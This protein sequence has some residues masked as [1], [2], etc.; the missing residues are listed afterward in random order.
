MLYGEGEK[1]FHRLQVELIR[2]STDETI[3]AWDRSNAGMFRK[4]NLLASS[5]S[6]FKGC[7]YRNAISPNNTTYQLTN[8]GLVIT[9]QLYVPRRGLW[10]RLMLR[11]R[12]LDGDLAYLPL[13]CGRGTSREGAVLP[14]RIISPFTKADAPCIAFCDTIEVPVLPAHGFILTKTKY[15]LLIQDL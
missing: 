13:R 10:S 12:S 14:L 7:N 5:L 15:Q 11:E 4:T 8:N 9:R 6:L 1:A 2:V 3:F